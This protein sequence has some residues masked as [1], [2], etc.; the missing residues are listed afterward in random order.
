MPAHVRLAERCGLS[1]ARRPATRQG[2][3]EGFARPAR[4]RPAPADDRIIAS[5]FPRR[6]IEGCRGGGDSAP[7]PR[8]RLKT[9]SIEARRPP[10]RD[11]WSSR[12]T[13]CPRRPPRP[14]RMATYCLPSTAKVIGGAFD[15]GIGAE[16][17]ELIER[18]GVERIDLARRMSGK[19]QLRR[20]QEP[21]QHRVLR[22]ETCPSPCRS[23]RRWR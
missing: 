21:A 11:P 3:S 14:T 5:V 7:T 10:S 6:L 1:P 23:S 18:L 15:A 8:H 22:L 9:K 13:I 4:P 17:P 12:R 19:H 2:R 16:L 20:C